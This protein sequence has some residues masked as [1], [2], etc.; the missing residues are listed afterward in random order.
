MADPGIRKVIVYRNELP[1]VDSSNLSYN[2]RYRIVSEDRNRSSAWSNI[3]NVSATAVGNVAFSVNISTPTSGNKVANIIWNMPTVAYSN[4]DIFIKLVGASAASSYQWQYAGRSATN[5]YSYIIPTT[6]LD[7]A[8][9]P[10]GTETP[11]KII[12]AVQVPST[13]PRK[14]NYPTSNIITLFESAEITI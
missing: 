14:E 13:P 3:T 8:N 1:P 7:P 4:F 11:T 2:I 6:I 10:S 5:S 9:P 12:V